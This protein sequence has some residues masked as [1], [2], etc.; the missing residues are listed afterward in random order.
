MAK[1]GAGSVP[2]PEVLTGD[3]YWPLGPVVSGVSLLGLCHCEALPLNPFTVY[4]YFEFS[5]FR[6][7]R[8]SIVNYL[9]H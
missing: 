7:E 3:T 5:G 8:E 9:I 6:E 2:G 4:L 1:K